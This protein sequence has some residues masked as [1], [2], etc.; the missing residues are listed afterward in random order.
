[1]KE[2]SA[3][4]AAMPDRAVQAAAGGVERA[5]VSLGGEEPADHADEQQ[6]QELQH[7]GQVLE[8]GHLPDAA[9]A[10]A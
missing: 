10:G 8:P 9:T 7:H 5:E 2:N 1:M 4:P 6:R 3:T